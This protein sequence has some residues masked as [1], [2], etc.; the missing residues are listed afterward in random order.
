MKVAFLGPPGAGKGTQAQA[1]SRERKVPHISTG[2][3][4][5]E[6]VQTGTPTGL[7][8]RAYVTA[9]KLV[10]DE[11][12]VDIVAERLARPDCKQGFLLDGFP[13]T[14]GQA[15]A[16]DAILAKSS[17]RLDAML[18][19]A[20]SDEVV[21]DRISGRRLCKSCG[22]NYHVK[23][24][25]PRKSGVCDR[26]GGGLYQRADDKPETVKERLRVYREQ[27]AELIDYYRANGLLKEISADNSV[28]AVRADTNRVLDA[29]AVR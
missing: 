5:R 27:T 23:Y 18:Y 10:P 7:K 9:G 22:A 26:C 25:A 21:V 17:M 28:E 13:R 11:I 3:I 20:V 16:L 12:V 4:L 1:V 8:A 14:L 24:I 6:A 15:K 29:V 19:Y 2:D